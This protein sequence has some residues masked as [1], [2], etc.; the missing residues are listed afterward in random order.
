MPEKNTSTPNVT[1]NYDYEE[2]EVIISEDKYNELKLI[3]SYYKVWKNS[4]FIL[5]I[6]QGELLPPNNPDY[7]KNR[8]LLEIIDLEDYSIEIE[9]KEYELTKDKLV[10]IKKYINEQ[11]TKLI[12]YASTPTNKIEGSAKQKIMVKIGN[13]TMRIEGNTTREIKDYCTSFI[14]EIIKIIKTEEIEFLG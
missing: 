3:E 14:N 10:E 11:V 1:D 2:Y 8:I 5:N 13:V 6:K 4:E 9:G 12:K 7:Y